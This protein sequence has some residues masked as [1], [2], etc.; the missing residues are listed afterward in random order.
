MCI[1]IRLCKRD[2]KHNE[3]ITVEVLKNK[4]VIDTLNIDIKYLTLSGKKIDFTFIGAKQRRSIKYKPGFYNIIHTAVIK[5]PYFNCEVY[6]N[7]VSYI[8]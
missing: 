6:E 5:D 4:D 8:D 3:S 7:D 1:I 2:E